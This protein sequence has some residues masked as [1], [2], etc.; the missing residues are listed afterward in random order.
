MKIF[1]EWFGQLRDDARCAHEEIESTS[2]SLL[3]LYDALASS[4]RLSLP[5]SLLRVALDGE[6]V[7]WDRQPRD[8]SRVVFLPPVGGG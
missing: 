7:D 8:G 3:Q 1:V 6:I 5:A 2:S 4:R